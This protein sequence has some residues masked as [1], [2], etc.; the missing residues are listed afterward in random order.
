MVGRREH[1]VLRLDVAMHDA[2]AV[3]FGYRVGDLRRRSLMRRRQF[4]RRA[5]FK[6]SARVASL[7]VLH[8]DE[9]TAVR[10]TDFVDR[11]DVRVLE[12]S[13]RRGPPAAAAYPRRRP[14]PGA[15]GSTFE[16]DAPAQPR[17]FREVN[18]A[19]APRADGSEDRVVAET[20]SRSER[21]VSGQ[22]GP[23]P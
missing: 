22:R 11:A 6:R 7:D 14:S 10:F 5:C 20:G 3:R 23:A 17:V 16:G 9:G 12:S 19:H 4:E 15:A 8:G 18:L 13:R 1:D 2:V 21:H